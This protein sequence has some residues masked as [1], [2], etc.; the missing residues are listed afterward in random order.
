M[1]AHR[2][3]VFSFRTMPDA[4]TLAAHL[5]LKFYVYGDMGVELDGSTVVK[6]LAQDIQ[7]PG[8][9]DMILHI[10]DMA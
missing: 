6:F 2:S 10:G 5:P 7:Q 4:S 9:V 3:D 8:D 1:L